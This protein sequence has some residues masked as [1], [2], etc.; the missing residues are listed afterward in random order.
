MSL[1]KSTSHQCSHFLSQLGTFVL[2]ND[3]CSSLSYFFFIN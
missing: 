1:I 3:K 2:F